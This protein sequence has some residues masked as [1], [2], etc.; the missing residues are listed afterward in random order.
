MLVDGEW[1]AATGRTGD[2]R[3]DRYMEMKYVVKNWKDIE[4]KKVELERQP[5]R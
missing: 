3:S 2:G 1:I 5:Y 4:A